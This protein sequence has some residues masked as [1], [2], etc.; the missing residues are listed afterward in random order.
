VAVLRLVEDLAPVDSTVLVEGPTGTGK[1]L[2][3]RAIHER[4]RRSG[5]AFLAMNCAGLG[6]EL[7][8]SQLFGHRRGAFTSAV[9]DQPGLFEAAQG[10]T[11]FLD[12]IGELPLRVQTMLLRV[13]EER[14]VMRVGETRTRPVDVRIIAA[15]NRDLAA[16][17]AAGRFRAD[18]LYRLRVARISVP[19][20]CERAEDIP[21]LAQAFLAELAAKMQKPLKQISDAAMRWLIS[22]D[23]PGNVRQLRNAIEYAVVRSRG[24]VLQAGD[25]PPELLERSLLGARPEPLA[26]ERARYLTALEQSGGNRKEAA[27]LL[28]VSRAT[29]YRRLS[30]LGL[31]DV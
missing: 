3:A 29:F 13:L 12:E 20:L 8:C 30:Q 25:L 23:W 22:H 6:E 28:G 11:L 17:V 15:T 31:D 2:V 7:A 16:E 10:G 9:E 1:E 24:T 14:V 21:L 4:S 26:D 27:R 5:R 18:L 19:P